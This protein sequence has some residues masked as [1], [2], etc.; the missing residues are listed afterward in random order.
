MARASKNGVNAVAIT[1]AIVTA[2]VQSALNVWT[3]ISSL[4]IKHLFS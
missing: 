4:V 3:A 1:N 2:N